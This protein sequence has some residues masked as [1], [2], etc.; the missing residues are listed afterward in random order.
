MTSPQADRP[1]YSTGD[2][3]RQSVV[4]STTAEWS[5]G[6][7]PA[8]GAKGVEPAEIAPSVTSVAPSTAALAGGSTHTVTGDNL[9]GSTGA[10]VGGTAVTGFTVLSETQCRFVA[11]ARAA[12]AAAIVVANPA[13]A[14]TGAVSITYA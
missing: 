12:G 10:T 7:N 11:P 3:V 2:P 6:V 5:R 1:Q 8:T 9:G 14:S 13:G 4:D